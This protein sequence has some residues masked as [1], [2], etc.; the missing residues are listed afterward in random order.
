MVSVKQWVMFKER[1]NNSPVSLGCSLGG[2]N[3]KYNESVLT[4]FPRL[5]LLVTVSERI[6]V[7]MVPDPVHYSYVLMMDVVFSLIFLS[8]YCLRN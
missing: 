4:P 5:L 3:T 6:M 7:Q 2:E 8:F 1:V